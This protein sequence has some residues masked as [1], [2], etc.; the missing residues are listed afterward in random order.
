MRIMVSAGEVSGDVHGSY[1]VREIK[2]LRPDTRFFGVGSERLAAEGVDIKFD[3]TQRGTI[4]LLE[5]LPNLFP[6]FSVFNK[7]KKLLLQEKP[8]LVILI[9][10]QGF[11]LPLAKFCKKIGVKTAYYIA[12]QEWLWGTPR[13]VKRVAETVDLIVAIFEKEYEAYKKAGANVVYFGHP[14]LDIV[15]PTMTRDVARK[16]FFGPRVTGPE[17][18]VIAIC[19]GSR[20][21][22]II[23]L[24]PILLKAAEMIQKETPDLFFLIPAASKEIY[25][26]LQKF[27][28]NIKNCAVLLPG[29][30]YD[31][32]NASNLAICAS[33]TINFEAS[34]LGIPNIMVYKLSPLTY[35]IGKYFLKIDKKIK[36]FSMPNIL[37]DEAVIPELVMG[38]ATPENILAS[39][40]RLLNSPHNDAEFTRLLSRLGAAGAIEKVARNLLHLDTF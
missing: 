31:A 38:D 40:R 34:I 27:T 8:D 24:F 21:Q 19:P 22:E 10:S 32:L 13:G 26:M 37:L 2:K 29:S 18:R 33:G 16:K 39:A 20:T 35:F 17:S 36:F 23:N 15:K 3:I 5:A 11:N 6:I 25:T 28:L 12:P 9:D 1:L 7:V 14:L 30:I 4:G